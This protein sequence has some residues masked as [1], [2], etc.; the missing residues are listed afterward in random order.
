MKKTVLFES[1]KNQGAKFIN[2]A[3]W[4]M[5]FSYSSPSQE[6]LQVRQSG[7]IFDVSHMGANL[8]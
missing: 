7:G 3:G 2:F 8:H 5:P 1:H 4:R 6:H